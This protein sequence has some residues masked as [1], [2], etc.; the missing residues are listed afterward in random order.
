MRLLSNLLKRFIKR[1]SLTVLAADGR[2]YVFGNGETPQVTIRLHDPALERKLFSNPELHAAEAYMDD[3]LTIEE[4]GVY[5]FLYLFSINRTGLGGHPVQKLLRA[6]WRKLKRLQQ[7]NPVGK[8]AD[9]AK[10]HYDLS[11][12]LYRLFL[13]DR[14]IYS[15]AF[16]EDPEHDTLEQAQAAKLRRIAAKLQLK[17][18][19]S[20]CEIGCGWGAMAIY[21]AKVCGVKVT[22]INVS[23][24]QLAEARRRGEAAGVG[25]LVDFREIDYRDLTG[26]FDRIVSIG[27]MEHV[28]VSHFDEYFGK[29]R[30][31]LNPDG[32]ALI[33][34][35]GRMTP[36]G[37][38]SPFIRK[39][40][41]PGGYVPA[42]S[43][44]FAS[45]E[46]CGLW[47]DDM[48]VLRL[49]YYHTIRHWRQRFAANRDKAKALYD[50]RFCRMWEFYLVAVELG[51]LNGSNMVFQ[52]ALST[53]RDALPIVRDYM[54]D[55]AR[56]LATH[57]Q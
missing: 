48:E 5:D 32:S 40:I 31:L 12:D 6:G 8:A 34:C 50:E 49:H 33:H 3:T 26:T 53:K 30:D 11:T 22:A 45:T 17:P 42:L 46:R 16:F 25:D 18:G 38:T 14:L 54:V 19:M 13:D 15:C 24:D 55:E 21:L 23:T 37:T 20:V 56:K 27:M 57:E 39:Y 10:S 47:V 41:F 36:P 7:Y 44:V 28:G 2:R 29:V 51:F 1:G 52:L 4:G 9:N 43:E 35:I